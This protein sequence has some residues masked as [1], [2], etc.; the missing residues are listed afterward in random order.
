LCALAVVALGDGR[1][2]QRRL[3]RPRLVQV[4]TVGSASVLVPANVLCALAGDQVAHGP[5]GTGVVLATLIA[6]SGLGGLVLTSRIADVPAL[7]PRRVL[8]IGAH[9][10]DLELGSGGT[11]AKLAD[12]GH[13]VPLWPLYSVLMSLVTGTRCGSSCAAHRRAGTS[14]RAPAWSAGP[15]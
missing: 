14:S 13:E 10:D 11:M 2:L 6:L 7:L 9:P 3:R 15:R 5:L 4:A 1:R 12:S 8:A